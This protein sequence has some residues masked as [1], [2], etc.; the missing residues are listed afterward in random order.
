MC[1]RR[2]ALSCVAVSSF[3]QRL[4]TQVPALLPPVSIA[5]F[6]VIA[7]A[8]A[9]VNRAAAVPP[10]KQR[11]SVKNEN[12]VNSKRARH[13]LAGCRECGY[14]HSRGCDKC[15][16]TGWFGKP[17]GESWM[18]AIKTHM[19]IQGRFLFLSQVRQFLIANPP[20]KTSDV[21]P[22]KPKNI[23]G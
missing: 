18:S 6:N 22:R 9:T 11:V 3:S 20:F 19:G 23:T 13:L 12:P 7:A 14:C 16:G 1:R 5:S 4:M 15:G 8:G 10:A 21:Y 17:W 2:F